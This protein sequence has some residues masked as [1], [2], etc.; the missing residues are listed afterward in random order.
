MRAKKFGT[1]ETPEHL[2]TDPDLENMRDK[3]WFKEL[4][5]L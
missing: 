5:G 4:A 3:P 1:L 2:Q